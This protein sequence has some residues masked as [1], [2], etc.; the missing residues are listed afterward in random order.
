MLPPHGAWVTEAMESHD[1]PYKVE[2]G[3]HVDVEACL[4]TSWQRSPV[5]YGVADKRYLVM[6]SRRGHFA[7]LTKNHM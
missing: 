2:Y 7:R 3:G 5:L 6:C 1:A 4:I